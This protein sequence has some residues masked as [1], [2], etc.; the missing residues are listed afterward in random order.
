MSP[1]LIQTQTGAGIA[2]AST[3]KSSGLFCTHCQGHLVAD[4]Y[5][6]R[7]DAGGHVWIRAM[8]CVRCGAIEEA[9]RAGYDSQRVIRHQGHARQGSARKGLDDEMIVL[10]T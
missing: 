8:R 10:G 5:I 7:V 3:T 6:D 4:L 1:H 9:G 2:T